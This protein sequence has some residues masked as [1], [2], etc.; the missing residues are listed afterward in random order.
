MAGR[1]LGGIVDGVQEEPL[2]GCGGTGGGAVAGGEDGG[3]GEWAAA[4]YI[5]KGAYEVADHVV[6]EAG[7]GDLVEEDGRFLGEAGVMD[8]AEVGVEGG[9]GLRVGALGSLVFVGV[10]GG[11]GGEVVGAED[12]V[13]GLVGKGEVDGP[14]AIPDVGS[15]GGGAD[16]VGF[17]GVRGVWG[18]LRRGPTGAGGPHLKGEMWGT[19]IC[20]GFDGA[21]GVDAVLVGF[22]DGT[23]AG[24]EAWGNLLGGED[25]DAGRERAIEGAEKVRG[26]DVGGEVEA[27]NLGKRVDSR[28]GAS[29][30]LGKNDFAGEVLDG[31]G[32]GALDGGQVRLDLP[33]ME[34]GAIVGEGEFPGPHQF[35]DGIMRARR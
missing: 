1:E 25:A 20:G 18:R 35:S 32:E 34:G 30:A 4:G 23:V 26:G 2:G 14:G 12:G 22:A 6:K 5:D 21:A 3:D 13:G 15:E 17:G 19:R 11:E 31:L 29:G 7:P 27:C 28:V 8:G 33:A 24:V 9:F 10:Y 16:A